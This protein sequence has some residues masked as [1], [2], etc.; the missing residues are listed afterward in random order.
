MTDFAL[1]NFEGNDGAAVPG[2]R[3]GEQVISLPAAQGAGNGFDFPVTSTKDVLWHW[4]KA[5]PAL[6]A[7]ADSFPAEAAQPLDDVRLLAP[8][9]YPDAIFCAFANF[10]DHMQEMSGRTPPD[11]TKVKPLHF[12][13]LGAHCV[14]GP[15]AEVRLPSH[16]QQ[17]DWEAELAVVIGRP[18]RNV[19]AADA[20][21]YVA[22]YTIVNDLSLRDQGNRKDWGGRHDFLSGKSFDTGAPMGP[23]IVPAGQITDV[24]NLTMKQWVAGKLQQDSDTSFMHFTIAEQIEDL[25]RKFTLRPGDVIATGSPSGNGRPQGIFLEPGQDLRIEIEG[26][27]TLHNPIVQGD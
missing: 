24:Y 26:I 1:L 10:T 16:S 27:G 9:L 15:E 6:G 22:G 8:I 21:D 4:D 3:V 2:I 17:V 7:L 12:I 5:L 25:S 11:K 23:W 14:I 19:S 20:M 13:K 18:A